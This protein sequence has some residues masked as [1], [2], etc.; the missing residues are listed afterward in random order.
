MDKSDYAKY[1]TG[2]NIS[3]LFGETYSIMKHSKAAVLC[4]GTASLEAALLG[5]TQI[6]CYGGNPV[7]AFI[8]SLLLKVK[9]VSLVNLIFN[10]HV[11]KELLPNNCT[12]E[13][14][15]KELQRNQGERT[16]KL[17]QSLKSSAPCLAE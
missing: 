2:S 12:T 3:L 1:L 16:K 10:Q 15:A 17:L 14:M 7:S 11:V 6:V 8:A 13:N 5:T 9:F 4:S